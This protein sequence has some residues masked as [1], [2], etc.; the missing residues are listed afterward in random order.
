MKFDHEQL[1]KKIVRLDKA[2]VGISI[3][4]LSKQITD[5]A[6]QFQKKITLPKRP[7][8]Q[9]IFC[10]MGGSA[11][12]AR[13]IRSVYAPWLKVPIIIINGYTIP[14]YADQ[15]SL[16][17]VC[18]YSGTTEEELACFTE[19]RKRKLPFFVLTMGGTLAKRAKQYRTPAFIFTPTFNPSK[20]PR[21]GSGYLITG[22]FLSL[23]ARGLLKSGYEDLVAASKKAII[24]PGAAAKLAFELHEKSL[25]IIGAEFLEGNAHILSN[26]MNETAK[27]FAPHFYLPELNHH[28]LE[29]F[30]SLKSSKRHWTVLMLSSDLYSEKVRTRVAITQKVLEKQGFKVC[31]IRYTGSRVAQAL[32]VLS[33]GS[34]LSYYC[35]ILSGYRPDAIPWVDY[36]KKQL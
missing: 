6:R 31:R 10:G 15:N 35:G 4:L 16:V 28:L 2:K 34:W 18:S 26:Q 1:K 24:D 12:G 20:Q 9:V 23:K 25:V 29:G 30:G 22:F 11:L 21:I 8:K 14:S 3:A 33:F 32:R 27:I 19:A 13:F 17:V 5:A 36:F 7:Y